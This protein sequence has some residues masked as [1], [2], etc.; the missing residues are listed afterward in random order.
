[1]YWLKRKYVIILFITF[2]SCSTCVFA[3]RKLNLKELELK[4]R[5]KSVTEKV[6]KAVEKFGEPT[7]SDLIEEKTMTFDIN[8]RMLTEETSKDGKR[9][10][11]IFSYDE[12]G[13]LL[14]IQLL[15]IGIDYRGEQLIEGITITKISVDNKGNILEEA[16]YD[17]AGTLQGKRIYKYTSSAGFVIVEEGVYDSNGAGGIDKI[18]KF[19][20]KGHLVEAK[21]DINQRE[22]LQKFIYN[23]KGK[24]IEEKA[25][26][27]GSLLGSAK[28]KYD[29]NDFVV[30]VNAET[31]KGLKR[32][33]IYKYNKD[34]HAN[35]VTKT[36]LVAASYNGMNNRLEAK[37]ITERDIL[38]Y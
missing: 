19:D 15:E 6:Y 8:G 21:N 4:G 27:G 10:K 33:T 14:E 9:Q 22:S 18:R 24:K 37:G 13:T 29:E 36:E 30:E 32:S 34:A 28:C 17:K 25:Y 23:A 11:S 7:K 2:Y 3:Q 38:Y 5:V 31:F 20:L 16:D 26:Y 1:M 12:K 35:Y